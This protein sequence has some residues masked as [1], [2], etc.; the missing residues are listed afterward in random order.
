MCMREVPPFIRAWL[1][2]GDR[3]LLRY[4]VT[5]NMI[6]WASLA[7][8]AL[9]A[10]VFAGDFLVLGG[11]LFWA[12]GVM[13]LYDGRVARLTRA[14]TP[15]GALLD[16]VVDRWAELFVYTGLALH[17]SGGVGLVVT[18]AALAGSLMVSYVR[19]RGEGLGVELRDIGFLQRPER[20]IAIGAAA[21]LAGFVGSGILVLTLAVIAVSGAATAISRFRHAYRVLAERHPAATPPPV[22]RREPAPLT[23][24]TSTS[25]S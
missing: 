22:P 8:S 19:A 1:E 18:L 13:D 11:L 4:G 25:P 2:P 5:P 9:A 14:A 20:I 23:A 17:F 6:T 12:T 21:I 3:L 10:L 7:T 24:A 16:S 15:A